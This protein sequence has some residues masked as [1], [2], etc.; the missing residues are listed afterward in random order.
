MFGAALVAAAGPPCYLD[1]DCKTHWHIHD[2]VGGVVHYR[3]DP[4]ACWKPFY[5]TTA[6]NAALENPMDV[7]TWLREGDV[8][9]CCHG[10][11]VCENGSQGHDISDMEVQ[12]RHTYCNHCLPS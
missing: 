2:R 9:H 3:T 7:E 10:I 11:G 8:P 4:A 12:V 6:F 5:T 1:C